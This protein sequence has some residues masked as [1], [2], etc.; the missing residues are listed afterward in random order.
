M[1]L[2]LNE[3]APDFKASNEEQQELSLSQFL[4]KWIVLYFYPGDFTS[5]CT[6][7]ACSFRDN[8]ARITSSGAVVL[9]VSPDN[10]DKH[11]RFKES[12]QLNYNLIAD[13]DKSIC[14]NYGVWVEK[15]N[16]GRKHMGVE[17]TTFIINPEGKIS[18]I[19]PKV[20]VDGHVK[21]VIQKLQELINL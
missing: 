21:E 12:Y 13:V 20:K 8:M 15:N 3:K 5:G 2:K 7:E 10:T 6:N 16:Y 4:G 9:G 1:I 14:N 18:Y 17:R 11:E 19:F